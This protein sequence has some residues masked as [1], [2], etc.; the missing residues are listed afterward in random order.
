MSESANARKG[1]HGD[2][3]SFFEKILALPQR[4]E[5]LLKE[6]TISSAAA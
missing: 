3:S 1:Q 2:I 4:R 6:P 5:R